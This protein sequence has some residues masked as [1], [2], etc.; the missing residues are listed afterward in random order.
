MRLLRALASAFRD[1][2]RDFA[3][4]GRGLG[5]D[6]VSTGRDMRRSVPPIPVEHLR[7]IMGECE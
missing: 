2:G 7:K 3:D 4:A 5:R 6:M 1:L